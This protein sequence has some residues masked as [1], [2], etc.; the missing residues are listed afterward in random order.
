MG[1]VEAYR[2]LEGTGRNQ[3]QRKPRVEGAVDRPATETHRAHKPGVTEHLHLQPLDA[4]PVGPA[5]DAIGLL[6]RSCGLG[7]EERAMRF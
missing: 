2:R 4:G 1:T 7:P 5:N 3:G 6:S